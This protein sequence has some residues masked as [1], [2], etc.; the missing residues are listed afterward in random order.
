[1]KPARPL[2][3]SALAAVASAG[4]VGFVTGIPAVQASPRGAGCSPSWHIVDSPNLSEFDD[5][6]LNGVSAATV[7]DVWA[8]GF[9]V[10]GVG[11]PIGTFA[12]HWDGFDWQVVPTPDKGEAFN[13]LFGVS[14]LTPDDVWAVGGYAQSFDQ[15]QVRPLVEHWDGESWKVFD[16][17]KPNGAQAQ[18]FGVDAR[19]ATDVWAVGNKILPTFESQPL[20]MHFDGTEWS[21][22]PTR[23]SGGDV[24]RLAAVDAVTASSA[25]AVGI[26]G[27]I[28]AGDPLIEQWDGTKW[29]PISRPDL[30]RWVSMLNGVAGASAFDMWAVGSR[31]VTRQTSEAL[32]EHYTGGKW[33]VVTGPFVEGES[34][35]LTGVVAVASDEVW[36]IGVS[37][38]AGGEVRTLS[39]FWTGSGWFVE[40][41]P[42]QVSD[43]NQLNAIAANPIGDTWAVGYYRDP[44]T[45]VNHTLVLRRCQ[46]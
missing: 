9:H 40:D 28:N 26:Q 10:L 32:I 42:N 4:L 18:L 5:S 2:A 38:G 16:V 45:S 19:S 37:V 34:H 12:I 23:N 35:W 39:E 13:V 15:F 6:I 8:V 25:A 44:Q 30:G 7:G 11:N 24:T 36:A 1:M 22:T 43:T 20:I 21:I 33:E 14:A 41:T 31:P 27:P 46:P 3:R 17:P 29:R